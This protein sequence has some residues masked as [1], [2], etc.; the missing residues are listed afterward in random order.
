MLFI[1]AD[2]LSL[3]TYVQDSVLPHILL[4]S[5]TTVTLCLLEA[6]LELALLGLG[7]HLVH[8]ALPIGVVLRQLGR[9]HAFNAVGE[10][11]VADEF[12]VLIDEVLSGDAALNSYS[13]SVPVED[14]SKSFSR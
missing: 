6:G 9:H 7:R 12:G 4:E 3:F 5:L 11:D 14:S 8:G 2:L 1:W 13:L 10:A